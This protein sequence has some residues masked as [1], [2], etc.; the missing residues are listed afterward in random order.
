MYDSVKVSISEMNDEKNLTDDEK[1]FYNE[2]MQFESI[3][4]L[5][6]NEKYTSKLSE[7][8]EL[9]V[10]KYS[11]IW[12][13]LFYLLNYSKEVIVEKNNFGGKNV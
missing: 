12:Q 5:L 1:E 8:S 11:K 6:V 4:M 10:I 7:M 2:F 3:K 13:I 9:V